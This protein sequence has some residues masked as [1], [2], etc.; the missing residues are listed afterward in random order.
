MGRV[1]RTRQR[2]EERGLANQRAFLR[3][4]ALASCKLQV[5]TGEDGMNR[6]Y[7]MM[8]KWESA[9]AAAPAASCMRLPRAIPSI[10]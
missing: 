10:A 5:A 1:F 7:G 4:G 9:K 2:A 3:T 8:G 6:G